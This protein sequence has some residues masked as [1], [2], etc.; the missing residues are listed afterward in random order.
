MYPNTWSSPGWLNVVFFTCAGQRC[1]VISTHACCYQGRPALD[2]RAPLYDCSNAV[3]VVF[4]HATL[5]LCHYSCDRICRCL[6]AASGLAFPSSAFASSGLV[7][8]VGRT[9]PTR[10]S[11]SIPALPACVGCQLGAIVGE[12]GVCAVSETAMCSIN[13]CAETLCVW[14]SV[15]C[16]C[17][18]QRSKCADYSQFAV[19]G[20]CVSP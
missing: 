13:V 12:V 1:I 18:T 10:T 5:L 6:H 9:V 2:V 4:H 8:M 14:S 7:F 11:S 16:K 3:S 19:W 20:P 17:C 15:N